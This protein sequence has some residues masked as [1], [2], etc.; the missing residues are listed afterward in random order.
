MKKFLQGS[1]LV[2]C[3]IGLFG[4]PYE[5]K[6]PI[7]QPT[8][9]VNKSMLGK[10][11]SKDEVYNSYTVTQASPTEYNI[12]QVNTLGEIKHYKGFLSQVKGSMFMNV[13]SDS[14]KAYFLYKVVIDAADRFTLIPFSDEIAQKFTSSNEL[15][16]FVG[17]NM[18]LRSFYKLDDKADFQQIATSPGSYN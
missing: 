4:C 3:S 13:Y 7:S 14:T 16:D 1:L 17:K 2:L 6:V 11:S 8:I 15:Q 5:S 10:W 9:P 12:E 18:N